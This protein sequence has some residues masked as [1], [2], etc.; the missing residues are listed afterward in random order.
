MGVSLEL[1]L[2]FYE[3]TCSSSNGGGSE[4]LTTDFVAQCLSSEN[5]DGTRSKTVK[6]LVSKF[7]LQYSHIKLNSNSLLFKLL[8]WHKN[9]CSQWILESFDV[10]LSD[11]LEMTNKWAELSDLSIDLAGWKLLL[12]HYAAIDATVIQK[13]LLPLIEGDPALVTYTKSKF[14]F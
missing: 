9:R 13:H 2:E 11:I 14:G 4:A 5:L 7:G 10:P 6:W 3:S 1:F 8:S 12:W